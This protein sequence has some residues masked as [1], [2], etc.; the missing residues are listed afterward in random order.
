M[1]EVLRRHAGAASIGRNAFISPDAKIHTDRFSIGANSWVASGAI[2]RG[3]VSIGNNSTINPYAHIAGRV[4]IG[5]GV[6]I[7][8]QAA[9]YGFNHG[10]ERTDIPIHQQKQTSKGVT[11]GDGSWVGANA[12]ILDGVSLGRDCVVGAGAVV[13]R[14]FEDFSIIAGNP[15]RLIGTRGEPGAPDAQARRERPAHLAVRALLYADDPYDELPFS[16]PA[17][18]QGWDSK[19]PVFA[20]LVGELRPGLIVE[21]GTWKGASAVHMAGVCRKLGLATEIVCI[22]TWLGNW[23]HW[24]RES[25]VG[26]K[27]DLRIVNG[28]PRLYYQFM[29]NVLHFGFRDSIT[30]LPL[31]GVAGAKLFKHLE[32]R[33]DLIYI[34]GDHEYESVL[35]D[36]RLWLEQLRPGGA[37]IGD[38]YNWPG[39]RRAVEEILNDSALQFDLHDR[40]FVLRRK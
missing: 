27:L 15:A 21:V 2:V 18:L 11:I 10:F 13:T 14:G 23:Q 37:I 39:V 38:D 3:N 34:D 6:R 8:G 40:K 33:P 30:P 17:D 19:H 35:F 26:S 31:T 4:D 36:L 9:I 1:R 29:A 12:V 20:D 32:I 25:G 5:H 7:A 24:S 28:F 16:Y 22:D